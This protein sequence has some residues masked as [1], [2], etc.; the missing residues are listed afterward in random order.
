MST[1]DGNPGILYIVATPIGNLEDITL[2]AL[3]ILKDVNLIAA[4]DT[5]RTRKLLNAYEISTPLISL[6]EHNEKEKSSVVIAKI[7]SGQSVAYVTDAGTP[8]ISDPGYHLVKMAQEE[9]IRVI[10]VPGVSAVITALS[11]SGF[12]ADNFLFCGFLPA[13][14]NKRIKFLKEIQEEIRTVVFY[15]SPARYLAALQDMY[16]VLGDRE[17]VIARELTK[18]FEEIRYGKISN[19]LQSLV[20]AKA[21]GEF[22]ILVKGKEKEPAAV[23][24]EDIEEKL[25]QLWKNKKMS[26]RDAVDEIVRET[27][28]S[29][30]KIY[31]LALK[32][33]PD[34]T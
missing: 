32:L 9:D 31:N 30:K 25:M 22:T 15:E 3:R 34:S 26:V 21:K 8:C 5:R 7:K 24:T 17:I 11:A 18:I 28:S 27:G 19:F 13:K 1:N 2:R 33:R 14:E 4:E 12:P 16:D 29:R 20:P 6:H 23:T 10:P